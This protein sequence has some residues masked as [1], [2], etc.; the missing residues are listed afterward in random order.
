MDS[1]RIIGKYNG[2]GNWD[3]VF[4]DHRSDSTS[5]KSLFLE[6]ASDQDIKDLASEAIN[7]PAMKHGYNSE[8]NRSI[9]EVDMG[10]VVGKEGNTDCKYLKIILDSN[11]D[12]VSFYPKK[13]PSANLN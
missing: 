11:G 6:S 1:L 2:N 3:H 12:V 9:I 4:E 7:S 8:V 10:R 13:N 5:G